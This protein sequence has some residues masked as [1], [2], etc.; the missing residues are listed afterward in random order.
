MRIRDEQ[1]NALRFERTGRTS[2]VGAKVSWRL[3]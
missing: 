1:F 3:G 2:L